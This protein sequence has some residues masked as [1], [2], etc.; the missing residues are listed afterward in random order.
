MES[1]I[2]G[3]YAL[4]QGI[5]FVIVRAVSDPAERDLPSLVLKAVDS[6]GG[7]NAR[8]HHRR[9]YPLSMAA[10]RSARRRSRQP[11]RFPGAKALPEPSSGP[12]PR[13]RTGGCLTASERHS[14]QR[15]T[16]PRAGSP[17]GMSGAIGPSVLT[18]MSATRAAFHGLV[19][20]SRT[21]VASNPL[22]TMQSAH[23]S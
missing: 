21:A 7:I 18:P 13:P 10:H 20:V 2:A 6:E 5:P 15:R 17:S 22:W 19:T 23:F 14:C 9:A 11:R 12:F 16:R 4:E 8:S 1:L 3:R